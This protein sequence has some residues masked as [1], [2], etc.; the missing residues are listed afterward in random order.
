MFE[1]VPQAIVQ[2]IIFV[3]TKAENRS[4]LQYISLA[5]SVGSAAWVM[6]QCSYYSDKD[7]EQ[8]CSAPT[9]YG[10]FGNVHVERFK[11]NILKL[12]LFIFFASYLSA[13]VLS[14]AIL[15]IRVGFYAVAAHIVVFFVAWMCYVYFTKQWRL[16][17]APY[18]YWRK[19]SHNVVSIFVHFVT[20]IALLIAPVPLI[21]VPGLL[22]PHMYATLVPFNMLVYNGCTI[23]VAQQKESSSI[24]Q[25]ITDSSVWIFF[26]FMC[27]LWFV[28]VVIFFA[29]IDKRY[30]R[31][32]YARK[33][34]Y[35]VV[36]H[37]LEDSD[38][39]KIFAMLRKKKIDIRVWH[40]NYVETL[41]TL[42]HPFYLQ[43]SEDVVRTQLEKYW[44]EWVR[45]EPGPWFSDPIW[46][47]AI[48]DS[49][50]PRGVERKHLEIRANS[51]KRALT[52]VGSFSKRIASTIL[53][54]RSPKSVYRVTPLD[55]QIQNT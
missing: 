7:P 6:V 39:N 2:C 13:K 46:Q 16:F 50:W 22:N 36:R 1:S 47:H 42:R 11:T 18:A 5:L 10:Y 48:P 49:M 24:G 3:T 35:D 44:P 23:L 52:N 14:L 32:F 54:G 25:N 29:N 4:Q 31:S 38:S 37:C 53:K 27:S 55:E 43:G 26:I 33:T 51:L 12:S 19:G 17:L 9:L 41:V 40:K 28:A 15:A 34:Y 20:A 21:R 45:N 30:T 8:R